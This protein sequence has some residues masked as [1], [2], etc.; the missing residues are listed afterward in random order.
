[1]T[2]QSGLVTRSRALTQHHGHVAL[3]DPRFQQQGGHVGDPG[4]HA[5]LQPASQGVQ[6]D[7]APLRPPSGHIYTGGLASGTGERRAG[8]GG[9]AGRRMM[10]RPGWD[11]RDGRQQGRVGVSG[12][13]GDS[14]SSQHRGS[15]GAGGKMEEESCE[16]REEALKETLKKV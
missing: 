8:K 13:L 4:C 9:S 2:T 12:D 14:S 6:Q 10:I 11:A 5:D 15:A 1:M 16:T 7:Q 3:L